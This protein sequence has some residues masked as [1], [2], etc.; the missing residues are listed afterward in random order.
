VY[1]LKVKS[2]LEW[3][4]RISVVIYVLLKSEVFADKS[5]SAKTLA[6]WIRRLESIPGRLPAQVGEVATPVEVVLANISQ[7]QTQK[8]MLVVFHNLML[9]QLCLLTLCSNQ[10]SSRVRSGKSARINQDLEMGNHK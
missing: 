6:R 1:Q 7:L 9:R 8:T 2:S 4:N 3:Q 10:G 5:E